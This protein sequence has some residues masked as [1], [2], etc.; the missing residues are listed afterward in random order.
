[1][2]GGGKEEGKRERR[3]RQEGGKRVARGRQ[4]GGKEEAS[5]RKEMSSSY[6][7]G[8]TERWAEGRHTDYIVVFRVAFGTEVTDPRSSADP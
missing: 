3:G 8:R 6:L 2:R 1:V 7:S 5:G 4:E